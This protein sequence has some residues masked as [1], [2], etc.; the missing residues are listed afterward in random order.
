MKKSFLSAFGPTW[1]LSLCAS[2]MGVHSVGPQAMNS[3]GPQESVAKAIILNQSRWPQRERLGLDGQRR[4]FQ[5]LCNY[6]SE[7]GKIFGVESSRA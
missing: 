7:R 6:F 2:G 5:C 4:Y 3:N 1:S